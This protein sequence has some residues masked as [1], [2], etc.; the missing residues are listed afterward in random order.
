MQAVD[1][2]QLE[3][4]NDVPYIIFV[5]VTDAVGL[6]WTD[7]P[8]LHD[9]GGVITSIQKYGFQE[10][11]KF[12]STLPNVSGGMGAIKAGNGRIEAA[13][14]MS[15]DGRYD[16]PRGFATTK[17]GDW[18]MP[19]LAGVDAENINQAIA[20]AIDSNNLTVT[21]SSFTAYDMANL[22][23]AEAYIE[24]LKGLA[25]NDALPASV[26]EE[27]LNF[28]I[29]GV[30]LDY[31]SIDSLKDELGKGEDG[32]LNP[33]I[34]LRVPQVVYEKY[35]SLMHKIQKE[36]LLIEEVSKFEKILDLALNKIENNNE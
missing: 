30:N 35:I 22:W 31:K 24:L 16:L 5:K 27:D 32:E 2:N 12:D 25:Q 6:L 11:P 4:N 23:D 10:L 18:V 17:E 7:N 29:N 13:Y 21:G 8:K 34:S 20:Y 1:S 19:I 36:M 28:L 14:M 15:K 33:A 9:L 26:D 3:N